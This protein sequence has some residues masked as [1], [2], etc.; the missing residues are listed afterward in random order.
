MF[1]IVVAHLSLSFCKGVLLQECFVKLNVS[2]YIDIDKYSSCKFVTYYRLVEIFGKFQ[3]VL[4]L[5][6]YGI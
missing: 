4:V 5:T 3:S 6:L 1:I 2:Q